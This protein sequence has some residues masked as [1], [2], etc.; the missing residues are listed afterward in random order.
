VLL[1]VAATQLTAGLRQSELAEPR[2]VAPVPSVAYGWLAEAPK[3]RSKPA[4]SARPSAPPRAEAR[5]VLDA[6]AP[7]QAKEDVAAVTPTSDSPAPATSAAVE[8]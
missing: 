2:A 5:A 8:P 6:G 7:R 4:P 3:P 1:G